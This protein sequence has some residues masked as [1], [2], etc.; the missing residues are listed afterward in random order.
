MCGGIN[1]VFDDINSG[2]MYVIDLI[3]DYFYVIFFKNK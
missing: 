2:D 3:N 1:I